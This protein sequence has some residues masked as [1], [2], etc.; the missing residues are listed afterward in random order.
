MTHRKN[1]NAL[2]LVLQ[3]V[4]DRLRIW[5]GCKK[6]ALE[7]SNSACFSPQHTYV[8]QISLV[9][10]VR[11]NPKIGTPALCVHHMHLE[12]RFDLGS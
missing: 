11:D 2:D 12:G 5:I 6:S 4:T 3:P 1:I 10:D 9:L 7:T 8:S